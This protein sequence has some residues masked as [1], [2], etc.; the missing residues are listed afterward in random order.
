MGSC[1]SSILTKLTINVNTFDDCLYHLDGRFIRLSTLIINIEKISISI[2]DL[3]KMK[4]LSKLKCF[5]LTSIKS[6]IYYDDLIVP[7]LHQ[8][9]NLEELTLFLI[10]KRFK[11]AD[12]D[13]IQ[14]YDQ[15]LI[16]M[17]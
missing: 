2:S 1:F 16:H 5:S 14:L 17:P 11:L 10:I 8:M 9:S 7:L 12:I 13:G 15:I 4:Q 6:T 3:E